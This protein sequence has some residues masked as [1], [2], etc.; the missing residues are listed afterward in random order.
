VV[1]VLVVEDDK[2]TRLFLSVVL[3]ELHY[4]VVEA[5]NA[6]E[7]LVILHFGEKFDLLISD[8]LMPVIDGM[9]FVTLVRQHNEHIP[10]LVISAHLQKMTPHYGLPDNIAMLPKPF[11]RSEFIEAVQK[12]LATPQ[13]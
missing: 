9:H 13:E 1:R 12:V 3:E 4:E 2:N 8:L 6:M 5:P 10:I 11:S 7:A